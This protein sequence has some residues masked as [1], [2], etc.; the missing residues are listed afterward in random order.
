MTEPKSKTPFCDKHRGSYSSVFLS[1]AKPFD[2]VPV[3][4]VRS[5][6]KLK[7]DMEAELY[8]FRATL[9]SNSP[10][11]KYVNELLQR[12]KEFNQS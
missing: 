8:L 3:D 11:L 10:K 2:F 5:L 12:A 4:K 7:N 6:E 1:S 9:P